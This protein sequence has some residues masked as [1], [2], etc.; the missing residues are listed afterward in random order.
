MKNSEKTKWSRLRSPL[1]LHEISLH[2]KENSINGDEK[3]YSDIE[4]SAESCSAVYNERISNIVFSLDYHGNEFEQEVIEF[5]SV[6]FEITHIHSNTFILSLTNPPKTLKPFIDMLSGG[7]DYKVGISG[8]ELDIGLF[9]DDL[10]SSKKV[11]LLK[12]K[13]VKVN[14]AVISNAAKATIE[15][16]SKDNAID[17]MSLLLEHKKFTVDKIKLTCLIDLNQTEIEISRTGS[18]TS[19][20]EV[21]KLIKGMLLPQIANRI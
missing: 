14:S 17:D 3:G 6:K 12:V 4:I 18:F 1:S 16:T 20:T 19:N 9:L 21:I 15:V 5:Y 10:M 7:L 11:S 2:F 13:K 8:V